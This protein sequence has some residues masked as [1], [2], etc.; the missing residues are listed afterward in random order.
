MTGGFAGWR[1]NQG[2][3]TLGSSPPTVNAGE[4]GRAQRR[5]IFRRRVGIA[6]SDQ[7]RSDETQ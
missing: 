1:T 7:G 6:P 4:A 5:V 2:M 3:L